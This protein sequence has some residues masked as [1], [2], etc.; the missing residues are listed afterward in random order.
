MPHLKFT[1]VSE[2]VVREMSEK[3]LEPLAFALSCPEDYFSFEWNVNPIYFGGSKVE[4]L[5]TVEVAWFD[6]GQE[7]RDLVAQ[8]VHEAMQALGVKETCIF[9]T[10]LIE[11]SY[12]DNGQHY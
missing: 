6:R 8:M 12:Y 3:I 9:F 10:T 5:P 1:S 2:D 4:G 11:S 7:K